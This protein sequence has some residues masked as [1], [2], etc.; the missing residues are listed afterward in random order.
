MGRFMNARTKGGGKQEFEY[1]KQGVNEDALEYYNTKMQVYKHTYDEGERNIQDKR[2]TL[3]CLRNLEMMKSCWNK[4]S[5]K[6]INW[7]AIRLAI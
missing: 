3:N 4:L 2:L 5:K 1:K 6:T 7:A